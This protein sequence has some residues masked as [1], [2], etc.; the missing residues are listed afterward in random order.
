MLMERKLPQQHQSGREQL[1]LH[2]QLERKAHAGDNN[3]DAVNQ[4]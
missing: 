2:Q 3:S 1:D 4:Q